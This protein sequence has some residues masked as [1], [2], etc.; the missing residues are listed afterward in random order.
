MTFAERVLQPV[1]HR[2][3]TWPAPEE[4]P[5][6]QDRSDVA[7]DAE[8]IRVLVLT[9]TKEEVRSTKRK[10]SAMLFRTAHST[11]GFNFASPDQRGHLILLPALNG[12]CVCAEGICV[13]E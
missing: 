12:G 6:A 4:R 2:R 11:H 13:I 9:D 8:I 5:L 3:L 7:F 10:T 1:A